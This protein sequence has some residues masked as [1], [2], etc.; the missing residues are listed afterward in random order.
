M[1]TTTTNNP[2]TPTSVPANQTQLGSV[3][4]YA[5]YGTA[6]NPYPGYPG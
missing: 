4:P 5:N 2:V 3:D 1:A 6:T